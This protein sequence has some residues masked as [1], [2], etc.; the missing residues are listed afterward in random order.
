[1]PD[2][3]RPWGIHMLRD[4]LGNSN[5]RAGHPTFGE[6]RSIPLPYTANRWTAAWWVLTGRA[7]ALQWPENG[8]LEV[9]LG[10]PVPKER[11]Q[12]EAT[13]DKVDLVTVSKQI[14]RLHKLVESLKGPSDAR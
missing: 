4:V 5:C 9:I 7:Y 2:K 8:D 12:N 14:T 10:V 11:L 1:M 6:V 13:T 3:N